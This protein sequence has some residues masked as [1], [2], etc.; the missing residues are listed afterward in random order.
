MSTAQVT[1]LKIGGQTFVPQS[2]TGRSRK[3]DKPPAPDAT[4]PAAP[5]PVATPAL[6]LDEINA[7]LASGSVAEVK[8]KSTYVSVVAAEKDKVLG[9]ALY[10][11]QKGHYGLYGI[12]KMM[13]DAA[14]VI[15][16][17][18]HFLEQ[19]KTKPGTPEPANADEWFEMLYPGKKKW[20][21]PVNANE[22]FIIGKVAEEQQKP[23]N[24]VLYAYRNLLRP[25]Q[26]G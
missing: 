3:H 20:G 14:G 4:A 24:E 5:E 25:K 2:F 16:L 6:S 17:V 7:K 13:T 15:W 8:G 18:L 12:V 9:H 1:Q 21:K 23:Y 26:L 19:Y 10:R 22:V 11:D